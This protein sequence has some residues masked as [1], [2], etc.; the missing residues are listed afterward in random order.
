MSASRTV[1]A[2]RPARNSSASATSATKATRPRLVSDSDR[3]LERV[4]AAAQRAVRVDEDRL[5]T[6]EPR[7]HERLLLHLHGMTER[8]QL[9]THRLGDPR[10]DQESL[11]LVVHARAID[12]V[13]WTVAE[14]DDVHDGL[15]DGA[16]DL[17]AAGRTRGEQGGITRGEERRCS[18]PQHALAGAD[19]IR[20][21]GYRIEP[22][23]RVEQHDA[24]ALRHEAGPESLTQRFGER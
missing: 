10:I 6:S 13:L 17:P 18:G 23:H 3:G 8:S 9:L 4:D 20:V 24:G 22:G 15:R 16:H 11:A 21:T 1:T 14:V 19:R 12:G 5:R 7:R 2:A